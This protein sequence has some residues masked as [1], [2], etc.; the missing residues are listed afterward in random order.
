MNDADLVALLADPE[1]IPPEAIPR[2]VG[3]LER[4]KLVGR[5]MAEQIRSSSKPDGSDA[6]R[7]AE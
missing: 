7:C 3:Q 1:Q 5:M 6:T 4:L 2:V